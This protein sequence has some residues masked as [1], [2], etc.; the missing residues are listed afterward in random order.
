MDKRKGKKAWFNVRIEELEAEVARLQAVTKE[1]PPG[2]EVEV[3]NIPCAKC[4]ELERL[5]AVYKRRAI[6]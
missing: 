2:G 1:L 6:R 4:K 5:L 3:T